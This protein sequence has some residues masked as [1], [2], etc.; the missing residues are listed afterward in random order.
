MHVSRKSFRVFKGRNCLATVLLFGTGLIQAAPITFTDG[1]FT[2]SN[3][4]ITTIQSGGGSINVSQ[5]LTGG[6]PGAAVQINTTVPAGQ[7]LALE[8][9]LN[10]SFVYNPGTQGAI[11]SISFSQDVNFQSGIGVGVEAAFSLISQGGNL[12][13]DRINVP[14]SAGVFEAASASGLQA[15]DYDLITNVNTLAENT[16]E[17]P[18][19]SSGPLEFGFMG[20]WSNQ[21]GSPAYGEVELLDNLSITVNAETPEPATLLLL[22]AGL[23]GL[24][25]IRRRASRDSRVP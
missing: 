25:L 15:S 12:Y 6:D 22:G 13:V 5:T 8:Y 24:G 20:A 18:N 14:A 1:T 21:A 19:F 3:Y 17:H 23:A 4:S 9:L 7:F 16:T 10:P 2:L 11:S